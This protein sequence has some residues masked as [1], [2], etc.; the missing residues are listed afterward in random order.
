M[1]IPIYS[2]DMTRIGTIRHASKV[3]YKRMFNDLH[4][5]SFE[6][7][8]DDDADNDL[9]ETVHGIVDIV[10]G[11]KSV[12]KYR[13]CDQPESDI[14]GEGEFIQYELEHVIAFLFDDRIDGYLEMGGTGVYT[15]DI[16]RHLLSLQTVKRWQLGR[17]DFRYQFQYSWEKEDL[18]N[19][20]FS[21]PKCFDNDYHWTYD[22][23]S[24][25]WTINLV[26][27]DDV[28]NC[29]VRYG[30]NEQSIK[31]GRDISNL[32]TRL[33]CMG[34]GEG[35]NQTSIRTVNPTGKS[36]IDSPN[37]SKYGVISKLLTDSSISDEATLFAKG[38]AYLRELENPMYSYTVKA[39]DFHR[40]TGLEWDL[41]DE[42]KLVR[43][44]DTRAKL[45]L[46]K[47]IVSVEK[48]DIEGN[49]LDMT[50]EIATQSS[51]VSSTLESISAKTAITAQ[52][53]QGATNLYAMQASDNA[54]ASHPAVMNFY[55]PTACAKINQVLL[56][57]KLENFRAYETGAA[58]G[59]GDVRTTQEGGGSTQTSEAGGATTVSVPQ[60]TVAQAITSGT[61]MQDGAVNANT[62]F[63][64]TFDGD[65]MS[66]T[67]VA[68][69]TTGMSAEMNTGISRNEAGAMMN[70]DAGGG[71]STQSGGGGNTG[72][73]RNEAGPK[74][75]TDSGGGGSTGSGGGGSTGAPQ[76]AG[77]AKLST[78]SGGGGST[79]SGGGG[80]TGAPQNAGGAKLSTDSGGSGTSGGSGELN[81]KTNTVDISVTSSGAGTTGG[82]SGDTGDASPGTDSQG[83]HSHTVN[84]HSHTFS[85]SI[86]IGHNHRLSTGASATGAISSGVTK[87]SAD[88]ST[89]TKSPGT[90]SQGSHSHTVNAHH[91]SIGSHTHSTP[92]HTH[93]LSQT[94]HKHSIGSHTHSIPA[95]THGM[96]H[97]HNFD[98][99]SHTVPAHTHGMSHWH[100]FDAHSHTVSAHTHGMSHWHT[101]DAHTHGLSS[102]TH[103]MSHWHTID[104]H[105]H[106]IGNH[107]H[108]ITHRHEFSHYHMVNV[109][110]TVP[111][112]S[113]EI[114]A[115]THK[116]SVP[117][118]SH[119]FT[120][121]SH[122]HEIQYGIY[123]GDIASS[124]TIR[125]DG[126]E[127]PAEKV[128][129]NEI[130]VIPYL[131]KDSNGRIMRGTWHEVSVVPDKLTR[132]RANLFVQTFVT[133]Y[134][135]GNY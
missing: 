24:Y 91:H 76:N 61:P 132:I 108:D 17:C 112:I 27:A 54:D 106:P 93:S 81:T 126:E 16:I 134:T 58:A 56:S 59:G 35:V 120:L 102:H 72:V 66:N 48:S 111:A 12:G 26:R 36:Y 82:G 7:P 50:V 109:A 92:N 84:S 85:F 11:D 90:D 129:G 77:G 100:N 70:T 114:P 20:L 38:K 103:G 125:V 130:D 53:A 51:D 135:G 52:Y 73:P 30:R 40:V 39:L 19:A 47:R 98:A 46:D 122:T 49:P 33:Y 43:L 113:I 64:K 4:T 101:M 34:S 74:L 14:T 83:S 31:R 89:G 42:G 37:I 23:S 124:V 29:E 5:A 21:I 2:R 118:H 3:G 62:G 60:R 86:G 10:D 94:A 128:N 32:C 96:S 25:P 9:C 97:W 88:K 18:L 117:A 133:S 131:S 69:G 110:V 13:I 95:H 63:A 115:H 107:V 15:E 1:R 28:R 44:N 65:N 8:A 127:I 71:G 104:G 119:S 116:V 41:I 123:E 79:G 121:P 87:V 99:H 55:V 78:D 45:D 68:T 6:I 80:S 22:T 57:W 105:T 75:S 67:G